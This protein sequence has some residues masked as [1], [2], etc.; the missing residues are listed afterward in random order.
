MMFG[1]T[2]GEAD[3]KCRLQE[4]IGIE[5]TTVPTIV[6]A[7]KP[8]N[9]GS[10]GTVA[11]QQLQIDRLCLKAEREGS[12]EI[13]STV[14]PLL[15]EQLTVSPVDAQLLSKIAR[16]QLG[17][18]DHTEAVRMAKKALIIDN[19]LLLGYTLSMLLARNCTDDGKFDIAVKHAENALAS[20][21]GD[22]EALEV[23]VRALISMR[24][25]GRG[26]ATL[27]I[28]AQVTVVRAGNVAW[29]LAGSLECSLIERHRWLSLAASWLKTSSLTL[30]KELAQ[31]CLSLQREGEA[32]KCL[33]DAFSIREGI[34]DVDVAHWL[35]QLQVREGCIDQ[36]L[37]TYRTALNANSEGHVLHLFLGRLLLGEGNVAAAVESLQ[38]AARRAPLVDAACIYVE[39]A[40]LHYSM[41]NSNAAKES[42]DAALEKDSRNVAA[43][44]GLLVASTARRRTQERV[45]ALRNLSRLEPDHP[46]WRLQ[47]AS[48]E[49]E[50]KRSDP[51]GEDVSTHSREA[52]NLQLGDVAGMPGLARLEE[53]EAKADLPAS[54]VR[55]GA[56]RSAD[57]EEPA[58]AKMMAEIPA[59]SFACRW[60]E[61]LYEGQAIEVYS[62]SASSWIEAS[63]ASLKPNVVRVKYLLDGS[64]CE[65]SLLRSSDS[66]RLW[67][68]AS[69]GGESNAA[70]PKPGG[71]YGVAKPEEGRSTEV[72]TRGQEAPPSRE[73]S[74]Q[75]EVPGRQQRKLEEVPEQ[76]IQNTGGTPVSCK[77]AKT[78]R[79]LSS[80]PSSAAVPP[81]KR[82]LADLADPGLA[83]VMALPAAG[84]QC[85]GRHGH[86]HAVAAPLSTPSCVATQNTPVDR[87]ARAGAPS[88]F[89]FLLNVGDL[90]FGKVLGSGAFGAVY[91]GAYQ[92]ATVAIK[93][94]HPIDGVVTPEQI[95]EFRKEVVNLQALRH[96]RL[97][98]F[99]GAA[100]SSP[101]LCI[102]TELMPNGSLYD[103]LH[104][105][106]EALFM[107]E[108]ISIVS[109]IAEGVA[110]LHSQSPPFVHRDLKSMN[111]VL[112]FVLN[113]KLCDFGLTQS[114]EKTHISRR[115]NEGGSPR[116][117]A[118]EL[119]DSRGKITEKVDVW[120]L[121]CLALEVFSGRVPHEECK[122]L[123]QVMTKTLVERRS[124]FSDFAGVPIELRC[125]AELCLVFEPHQRLD[126]SEFLS[127]LRA[128]SQNLT[129]AT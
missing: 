19:D 79:S 113:I 107:G 26:E 34:C 46:D 16:V 93:K 50:I 45:R 95:E 49:S 117:M 62:K 3:A 103:L 121:G 109:Q 25:L 41:G 12:R 122:D 20:H 110:F 72:A 71:I 80:V 5:E 9:A 33:Q 98:S 77:A 31:V 129:G 38:R 65:K 52:P 40:D 116:Y 42:F 4:V 119:F 118:P 74:K 76:Q 90:C 127:E 105:K 111:V 27:R 69:N 55:D 87:A 54:A 11:T 94:L 7:Q 2:S 84:E 108:Q 8:L 1:Q 13:W 61:E 24:E 123:H 126:A 78:D 68:H 112:D 114:M 14:L 120:A 53:S 67:R 70:K 104:K 128:L 23:L 51:S 39:L 32:R 21:P 48:A 99:I 85:H 56:S 82:E 75:D 37:E 35:G 18:G 106:K 88:Q 101:N 43:W 30:L 115:D 59:A 15:Q 60:R 63:V 47:L 83:V 96:P 124:P 92:G 97:V 66:L 100:F 28:L 17:L 81:A 44:R 22:P 36:A 89:G 73:L 29:S 64:W 10:R 102:V 57:C 58:L 125:I 91:S 86:E 6:K